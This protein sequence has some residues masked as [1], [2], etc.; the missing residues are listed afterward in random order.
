MDKSQR[1]LKIVMV[2]LVVT[3]LFVLNVSFAGIWS[4]SDGPNKRASQ[5]YVIRAMFAQTCISNAIH[6]IGF[7]AI[8]AC[9]LNLVK[10]KET[11]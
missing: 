8:G 6:G 2:T 5:E 1:A 9:G 4:F 3:G 7:I 11:P 10:R